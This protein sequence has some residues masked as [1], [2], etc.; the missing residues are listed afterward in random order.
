MASCWFA[1][2]VDSCIVGVHPLVGYHFVELELFGS[3]VEVDYDYRLGYRAFGYRYRLHLVELFEVGGLW[4]GCSG[5]S[6][7]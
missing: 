3:P 1:I 6:E 5:C 7:S 4:I 2:A